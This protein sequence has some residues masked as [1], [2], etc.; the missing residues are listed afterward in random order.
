[1]RNINYPTRCQVATI[2]GFVASKRHFCTTSPESSCGIVPNVKEV[3]L[4]SFV[5]DFPPSNTIVY[6]YES[7]MQEG[8]GSRPF[9]VRFRAS[10]IRWAPR[11]LST[12]RFWGLG[13]LEHQDYEHSLT[14]QVGVENS[15]CRGPDDTW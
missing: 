5:L 2:V 15:E 13:S 14:Q 3:T 11:R 9:L 4:Q 8:E 12:Q 1:H 10:L 7:P 6:T